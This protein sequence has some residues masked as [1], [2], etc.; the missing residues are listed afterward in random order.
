MELRSLGLRT[1]LIFHRF[2]GEVRNLGDAL[3]VRTPSNPTFRWGNMLLYPGAPAPGDRAGWEARFVEE[4]GDLSHRVFGWDVDPA[5]PTRRPSEEALASFL[6]AGYR[7]E[8]TEVLAATAD[9]LRPPEHRH[10]TLEVRALDGA[11]EWR[12]A[13]ELQV[14][15]REVREGE[16]DYR[17]YREGRMDSYRRM[18]DAGLGDWYG[19]FLDDRLVASMGLFFDGDLGRFQTVDS[20]PEVRRRGVAG[21]MVHA[22]S[23][24]GLERARTLVL[25]ADP[26]G[27]AHRL[28]KRLGYRLR[29]V[30]GGLELHPVRGPAKPPGDAAVPYGLS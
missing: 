25:H 18:R 4:V 1:A 17:R 24:R 15:N 14:L 26:D 22:L 10:P 12:A 21:T 28:Y 7:L 6:E 29:E 9:D 2:E 27:P 13:I 23:R 19:G 16:E 20:H 30:I 11:S 5:D 8:P 3:A